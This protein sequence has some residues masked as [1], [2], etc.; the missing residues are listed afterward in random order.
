MK[1]EA[2]KFVLAIIFCLFFA[3]SSQAVNYYWMDPGQAGNAWN[4]AA[5]NW[6]SSTYVPILAYPTTGDTAYIYKAKE[7]IIGT[8]MV[9][10]A[11]ALASTVYVGGGIASTNAFLTIKGEA[12]FATSLTLGNLAAATNST[13]TLKIEPGAVLTVP[14]FLVGVNGTAPAYSTIG[15]V[16]M[17]GGTVNL[18]AIAAPALSIG[19]STNGNGTLTMNGGTITTTHAVRCAWGTAAKAKLVINNG[20]FLNGTT[21]GTNTYIGAYGLGELEINSGGKLKTL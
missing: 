15:D 5:G 7:C 17:L 6:G 10:A 3:A 12:A 18:T 2:V 9:G 14:M 16:N 1:K 13:G 21:T 19:A 8:D 4:N 20:A 11:K